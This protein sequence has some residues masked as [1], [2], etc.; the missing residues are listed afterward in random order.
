MGDMKKALSIGIVALCAPLAGACLVYGAPR[1][2]P[3]QPGDHV[4][5]SPR[6]DAVAEAFGGVK[7]ET[8]PSRDA[9][10]SF[11]F[12]SEVREVLVKGGQRVRKD[13]VL[14]RARDAEVVAALEQQRS[15]ASNDLEVQGTLLASQLAEFRF[16]QLKRGGSFA[17]S[18]FEELRIQMLTARVQHEVA[19]FNRDQQELRLRQLEAQAERYRL[20]APF[21]GVVSQVYVDAGQGVNEQQKAL[22]IVN[23]DRLWLDAWVGTEETIRL[24]VR[25]GGRAWVLVDVPDRPVMIEGRVVEVDPVADPVSQSR[26]VRVEIDN[27]ANW[28]A[29]TQARVRLSGPPAGGGNWAQTP[30]GGAPAGPSQSAA[31]RLWPERS[32]IKNPESF[33]LG[34]ARGAGEEARA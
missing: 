7:S 33:D 5:M 3:R 26:R 9:T 1:A 34:C 22:R 14:M 4:P 15:L 2:T 6:F 11:T 19:K 29:G 12:A 25:E 32:A 23:T 20:V 24:G 28:P 13:E 10:M 18:E 21:D 31:P 8:R 17:P 30:E 27:P 16:E